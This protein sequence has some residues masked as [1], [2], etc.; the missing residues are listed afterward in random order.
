MGGCGETLSVV[1]AGLKLKRDAEKEKTPYAAV[2]CVI[3]RDEHPEQRY[4]GAFDK[5]YY[6]ND[7]RVVWANEA[8][9][10]WYFLHFHYVDTALHRDDLVAKLSDCLEGTYEK[11][12]TSIYD[13][14]LER[15][16]VA[17]RNAQKLEMFNEG[18][19]HPWMENPSTNVHH[20]VHTLNSLAKLNLGDDPP[21]IEA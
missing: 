6:E 14:L 17:I 15:Q 5:A 2:F 10:L 19:D 12:D 11:S 20:L 21:T 16:P 1:N 4:R 18:A 7:L 3:D 13:Q 8:F 9:E